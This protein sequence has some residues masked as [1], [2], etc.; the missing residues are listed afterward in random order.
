MK[1][2]LSILLICVMIVGVFTACKDN[3]AEP[4]NPNSNLGNDNPAE[5]NVVLADISDAPYNEYLEQASKGSDATADGAL[6]KNESPSGHN[7]PYNIMCNFGT[8]AKTE[9]MFSWHI[10]KEDKGQLLQITYA[11]NDGFGNHTEY[12]PTSTLWSAPDKDGNVAYGERYVMRAIVTDLKPDTDYM[13][14][15]GSPESGWSQTRYFKTAGGDSFTFTVIS[16][17]Q[18]S[19][20]ST[21][22]A[23]SL[24]AVKAAG[25][26]DFLVI[27][28][29]ISELVGIEKHYLNFFNRFSEVDN[30]PFATVPGNHETLNYVDSSTSYTEVSGESRGYNGHFYN[31]QNGPV[32]SQGFSG[33]VNTDVPGKNAINSTY[34]FYYNRTLFIM[35]NTQQDSV[36]LQRTVEWMEEILEFDRENRLS[37]MTVV[38]MHKGIYGNRYYGITYTNHEIF[39]EVFEKYDIDLVMSGH[40][41]SYSVTA[42]KDNALTTDD[43]RIGTV[44]SIVGSP[45]PKLYQPQRDSEWQWDFLLD[46][47]GKSTGTKE[48]GVYSEITIDGVGLHCTA[49]NVDGEEVYSYFIPKKRDNGVPFTAEDKPVINVT[50]LSDRATVE[51]SGNLNNVAQFSIEASGQVLATVERGES[52]C[53]LYNLTPDSQKTVYVKTVYNDGRS[54]VEPVVITTNTYLEC[55]NSKLYLTEAGLGI[56]TEYSVSVNGDEPQKF[57]KDSECTLTFDKGDYVEVELLKNGYTLCRDYIFIQ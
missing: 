7:L 2:I 50:A 12:I 46:I 33:A 56:C 32:F 48:K 54:S 14:R 25:D 34:Y 10:A 52:E 43:E 28:G 17:P 1:K 39:Y 31:P 11:Y 37:D 45:G 18:S 23:E 42:P 8:D 57:S 47:S 38:A 22:Y 27:C 5:E 3:T 16:D 6:D 24:K 51:V 44:Y 20:N 4:D 15:V 26:N 49:Y 19:L 40:D 36:S 55:K 21:A 53:S 30:M 13:Y 35:L 41:H 9:M 29:D